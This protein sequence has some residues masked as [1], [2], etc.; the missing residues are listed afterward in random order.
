MCRQ[1]ADQPNRD[2]D[3]KATRVLAGALI[4]SALAVA[5]LCW[6]LGIHSRQDMGAYC[7]MARGHFHPAWKDL[8]LRRIRKGDSLESL[9]RY[10]PV[11]REDFGPYTQRY[12]A[13]S[14]GTLEVRAKNTR[15][16][17]ARAWGHTGDHVFFR[18]PEE[19]KAFEEAYLDYVRQRILE[20]QACRIHR[21]IAAGQDV[22][23]SQRVERSQVR[24]DPNDSE[25]SA[26]MWEQMR[27]IYGQAYLDQFMTQLELTVEVTEVLYGDLEP[28]TVLK[29][30]GDNCGDAGLNGAETVFLHVKDSRLL[31]SHSEGGEAYTTVP[32]EALDWYQSLTADEVKKL[33]ALRQSGSTGTVK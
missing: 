12:Y 19:E 30:P 24:Y 13:G 8:A 17:H 9:R 28:G 25:Y 7:A 4:V 16:I 27:H 33:E 32:R 2:R 3:K 26:K 11:R 18:A 6:F 14:S 15:L 21:V 20:S 10:R 22:F 5:F 23:L 1:C 29:F 31:W